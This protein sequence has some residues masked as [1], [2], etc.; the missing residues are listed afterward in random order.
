MSKATHYKVWI[1]IEG[2]NDEGDMVEGDEYNEPREAGC[3]ATREQAA[4]LRDVLLGTAE[5]SPI[6]RLYGIKDP[7]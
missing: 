7:T 2:L 6:R 3:F 4:E 1:H 5:Y